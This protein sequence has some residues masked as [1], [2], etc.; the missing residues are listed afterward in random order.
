MLVI[1]GLTGLGTAVKFIPRP[2]VVGFTNGIAVLIASTQIKDFFGLQIEKVPG[3]F[4]GRVEALASH[5]HTISLTSTLLAASALVVIIL[6]MRFLK[7]VPGSIVALLLGTVVVVVSAPAGR[8][9]RH[10]LRR[11]PQRPARLRRAAVPHRHDPAPAFA[12][13]D[14][15]LAG[16]HRVAD[17]RRR[18]RPDERRQAQSQRGTGGP[19]DRQHRRPV[20][21]RPA[22]DRAPSPAR[23]R[24]SG[25]VRRRRWPG[26]STPSPCS[27]SSCSPPRSPSTFRSPSSRRSCWWWPTT[28]ASGRRYRSSSRCRGPRSACGSSPSP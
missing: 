3:E 24:T 23:P 19:G 1:L 6:C 17:V 21:R 10:P 2:V 18:R 15:R 13:P 11:H 28:W 27:P 22:R 14:R 16:G 25:P 12:G 4:V 20:L 9:H 5:F 7:R 8:N 26:W